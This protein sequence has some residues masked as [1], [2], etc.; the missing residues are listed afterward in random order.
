[1]TRAIV[2]ENQFG[3]RSISDGENVDV[4]MAIGVTSDSPRER[5]P[6]AEGAFAMTRGA[7]AQWFAKGCGFLTNPGRTHNKPEYGSSITPSDGT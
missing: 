4:E 6:R 1:M 3:S 7:A 2:D 5:S